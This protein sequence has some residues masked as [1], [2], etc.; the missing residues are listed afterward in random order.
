MSDEL[1]KKLRERGG[2]WPVAA[3][4]RIEQLTAERDRLRESL[5][6]GQRLWAIARDDR[7]QLLV[8]LEQCEKRHE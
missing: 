6:C 3:A 5:R 7:V 8:Q 1:V 4:D 2:Q